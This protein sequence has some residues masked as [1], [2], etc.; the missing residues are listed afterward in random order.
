MK[1]KVFFITVFFS[2]LFLFSQAQK[3]KPEDKI[4]A[5]WYTDSKKSLVKIFRATNGNYYGKIIWLKE[6]LEDD[7]TEKIDD[8]NPNPKLQNEP[9][10]G[11][12]ILKSFKYKGDNT[13]GDGTIYDPE[14]GK[15]YKCTIKMDG[16]KINV[17]GF[18]GV[19]LLG[20]TTVWTKK[21]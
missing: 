14:N 3:N 7:G 11:L 13:W 4:W 12:M 5:E 6:P 18:I 9:I 19:S 21:K 2:F 1:S 16:D 15:T 20:R 17:R 10:I 8:E